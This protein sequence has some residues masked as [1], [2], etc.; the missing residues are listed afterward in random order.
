MRYE[1]VHSPQRLGIAFHLEVSVSASLTAQILD[2]S[3]EARKE[4]T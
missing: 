4:G 3:N 2:A 1:C